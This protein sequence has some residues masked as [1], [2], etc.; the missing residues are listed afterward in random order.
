MARKWIAS[1]AIMAMAAGPA[2]AD[3][4]T[5]EYVRTNAN[6]VLASLNAPDVTPADRRIKFQQYMDEFADLDAVA[7]FSIGK[8]SRRFTPEELDAYTQ[9]FRDYALAVYEFYFNEYKGEDVKV[10]GST[11]RSTRDSIVDTKIIRADGEE[12]DVRWRVLKRNDAYQVVDIALNAEGNLIWLGI[13][14]QA[15]FLS[16]L[17]KNGGSADALI[18]RIEAMTAELIA[19]REE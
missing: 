11:D 18:K 12:M 2:F 17:D 14:Q 10:T 7:R 9:T 3:A 5:E 15:Q 16:L 6:D 4:I 1:L 13:E 8:Y 19:E